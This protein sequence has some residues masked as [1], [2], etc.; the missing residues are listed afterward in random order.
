[1]KA[2][3]SDAFLAG[4][5][6][7]PDTLALLIKGLLVVGLAAWVLW[8]I[9][10]GW[11]QLTDRRIKLDQFLRRVLVALTFLVV[12]IGFTAAL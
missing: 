8:V 12:M 4:A 9:R 11:T 2:E 1:M 5:G 6:F 7:S 10:A 3:L